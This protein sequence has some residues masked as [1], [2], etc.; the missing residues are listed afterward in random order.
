MEWPKVLYCF[1]EQA[2]EIF[3]PSNGTEGDCFNSAF[4]DRCIH[5][6][7]THT[8]NHADKKC[9]ILNRAIIYWYTNDPNYPNQWRYNAEGWPICTEWVKWDWNRDDDGNWNDPPQ[10]EPIDPKQLCMPF[11]IEEI[12]Q[13]TAPKK[14]TN[15][16]IILSK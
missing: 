10:P 15:E 12:E 4:C 1:P 14:L 7:W 11:I 9:D 2:G 8:Q 6:K 13:N 5:E 3:M 16:P